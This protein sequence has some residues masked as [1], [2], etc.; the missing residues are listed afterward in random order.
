MGKWSKQGRG[1]KRPSSTAAADDSSSQL[2]YHWVCEQLKSIRQDLT[3]QHINNEFTAQVYQAHARIAL[4]NTDLK[5]F[6]QCQSKLTELYDVH[7]LGEGEAKRELIAYRILYQIYTRYKYRQ[8]SSETACL[9]QQLSSDDL[10]SN[11]ITH[12]VKVHLA[13]TNS[14]YTAVFQLFKKIPNE[15]KFLMNLFLDFIRHLALR[16]MLKVSFR[17]L[18]NSVKLAIVV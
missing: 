18:Q 17:V 14:N 3:V 6:N 11:S 16:H 2:N 9:L 10:R 15:G 8:I 7:G 12:A 1:V 4:Q 13:V 5:E